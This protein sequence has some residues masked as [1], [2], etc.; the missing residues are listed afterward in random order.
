MRQS[1][2]ATRGALSCTPSLQLQSFGAQ[3]N[4][5]FHLPEDF[6]LELGEA[7]KPITHLCVVPRLKICGT[8][9]PLT[10]KTSFRDV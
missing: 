3:V 5:V 1:D 9:P 10:H 6:P 8:M 4:V 7:I 2:G